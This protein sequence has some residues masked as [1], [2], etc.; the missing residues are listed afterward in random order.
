VGGADFNTIKNH[1]KNID[2]WMSRIGGSAKEAPP[3]E[4]IRSAFL[5]SES[6]IT[7]YESMKDSITFLDQSSERFNNSKT[8]EDKANATKA[9]DMSDTLKRVVL[10]LDPKPAAPAKSKEGFN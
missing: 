10:A 8:S 2:S 4:I 9:K 1:G 5:P 7:P 3:V 6:G